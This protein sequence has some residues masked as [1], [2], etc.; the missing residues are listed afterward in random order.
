MAKKAPASKKPAPVTKKPVAKATSTPVRNSAIPKP[1]A[2][3][4]RKPI[5]ITGD[6]IARRAFEIHASGNGGSEQD[7]WFAAERQLRS[8]V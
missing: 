4:A 3:T 2:V 6:M 8:G 5:E 7:N 1:A